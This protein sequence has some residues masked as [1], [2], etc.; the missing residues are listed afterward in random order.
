M[1]NFTI[2]YILTVSPAKYKYPAIET[3]ISPAPASEAFIK[4]RRGTLKLVLCNRDAGYPDSVHP[5][6]SASR[7]RGKY[8]VRQHCK[9]TY[10]SIYPG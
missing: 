7:G 8:F 5:S 9:C 1:R 6:C 4:P 2:L 10:N 3:T